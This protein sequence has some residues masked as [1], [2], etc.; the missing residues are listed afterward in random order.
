MSLQEL[1]GA[2]GE[3]CDKCEKADGEG[4]PERMRGHLVNIRYLITEFL[5]EPDA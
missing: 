4:H 1:I 3:N 2:I 5:G